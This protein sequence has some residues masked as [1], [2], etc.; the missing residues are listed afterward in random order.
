MNTTEYIPV[1]KKKFI[2]KMIHI[3]ANNRAL[4][5]KLLVYEN[6]FKTQI[7]TVPK[8][9][10]MSQ[11]HQVPN[12]SRDVGEFKKHMRDY[13]ENPTKNENLVPELISNLMRKNKHADVNSENIKRFLDDY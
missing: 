13:I 10:P 11:I 5:K 1:N 7:T 12:N 9:S 8:Q 3:E 2:R 6:I 4:Q